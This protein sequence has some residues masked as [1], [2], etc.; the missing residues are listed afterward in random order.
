[1]FLI[2]AQENINMFS[3][4]DMNTHIPGRD[5]NEPQAKRA[6]YGLSEE[7]A[8]KWYPWPDKIVS[9]PCRP[10]LIFLLLKHGS[11]RRAR[12]TFSCICR[13]LYFHS[14]NSIFFCGCCGSMGFLT[15]HPFEARKKLVSCYRPC[16]GSG[17]LI[18]MELLVTN[19]I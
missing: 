3:R 18:T 15:C 1:M 7:E 14:V 19:T 16:T 13:D 11:I 10:L 17:H 2:D 6:R 12:S 4:G 9:S 8:L 5:E